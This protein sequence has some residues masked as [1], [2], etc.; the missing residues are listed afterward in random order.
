MR[1]GPSTAR[2][3]I[4][5]IEVDVY[6]EIRRTSGVSTADVCA[7]LAERYDADDVRR[8]VRMLKSKDL[9]RKAGLNR[10]RL[11]LWRVI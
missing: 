2:L 6:E 11:A 1:G 8:I 4:E 9:I 7:R 10:N 5:G 3:H